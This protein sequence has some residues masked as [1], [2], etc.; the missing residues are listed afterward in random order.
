M[1]AFKKIKTLEDIRPYRL[2]DY[3][4]NGWAKANLVD[5]NFDVHL[6]PK[7]ENMFRFLVKG[8]ADLVVCSKYNALYLMKK[9]NLKEKIIMLPVVIDSLKFKLCVGKNSPYTNVI[10]RFDHTIRQMK[11]DG[12]MEQ[13][14][15]MYQ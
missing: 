6:I 13:I 12:T 9:D 2:V 11:K 4:G 3:I 10:H 1:D 14:F 7:A 15:K 5:K 8:R